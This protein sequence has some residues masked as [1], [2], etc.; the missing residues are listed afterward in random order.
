MTILERAPKS[1]HAYIR[2]V[3]RR[4][5]IN[6]D[7]YPDKT[8]WRC[9][10]SHISE[11]QKAFA[12]VLGGKN[13]A[14][15]VE[16]KQSPVVVDLMASSDTLASLF[17]RLPDKPKLGISLSLCDDRTEQ[18]KRRDEES[19]I[20][21]VV[22]DIMRAS[23]WRN[24]NNL[25]GRRKADL[26]VER[27]YGALSYHVPPELKLY[28]MFVRKAWNMLSQQDGILLAQIMPFNHD[29]QKNTLISDWINLL[30]ETNI[31]ASFDS[32]FGITS[33][34]SA[35]KIVKNPRSPIDLPLL[36]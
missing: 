32:G 16:S 10:G 28:A 2:E 22:G 34:Y 31:D 36:Q 7:R 15:L 21:H 30:K 18:Q 6:L 20:H 12:G 13:V 5:K 17:N 29:P 14:E 35:I 23:A 3:C 27:G 33:K 11:Y 4:N 19:N 9:Y 25:L 8:F 26:V 1:F 24:V